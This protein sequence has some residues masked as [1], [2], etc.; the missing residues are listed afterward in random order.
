MCRICLN[1]KF[2]DTLH[3]HDNGLLSL[4][5][6]RIFKVRLKLAITIIHKLIHSIYSLISLNLYGPYFMGQQTSELGRA[7]ECWM[8]GGRVFFQ[9]DNLTVEP[10]FYWR[11][12]LE[13]IWASHLRTEVASTQRLGF[14][15]S[16]S[17]VPW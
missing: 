13:S 12:G 11:I 14:T 16:L 15:N 1:R 17:F 6:Y 3:N 5:P 4:T 8:F 2:L 7:W 10:A 9:G